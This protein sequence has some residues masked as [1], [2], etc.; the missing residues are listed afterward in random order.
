MKLVKYL[1]LI[2]VLWGIPSFFSYDEAIGSVFSLLMVCALAFYYFI[3][4]KRS[5]LLPFIILGLLY[6]LISGLVMVYGDPKYFRNDLIKYF[7]LIICGAELA[8][9]TTKKEL[10]VILTLGASSILVHALFFQGGFGRYS[11]L[12][13]DPNGAGFVC[14]MAYCLSFNIKPKY[15]KNMG[16]FLVTFAGLLTFSR[17]FIILWLLVSLIAVV[18]DRKNSLNFGLGIGALIIILTVGSLL[19]VDVN[20]FNALESIFNDNQTTQVSVIKEDS[21]TDT[22]ARYYDDILDSPIFGNG[23][24]QLSGYDDTTPGVHNSYLMVIGEAGIFPFLVFIG[25]YLFML[26]KNVARYKTEVFKIMFATTLFILLM[27]THNYFDNF[28]LI[29]VSVWLFI[30]TT[31]TVSDENE[32]EDLDSTETELLNKTL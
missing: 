30:Q 31:E 14:I 16:Q 12:Y 9:D 6:F 19:K 5:F 21:R 8:R 26:F 2:L 17:T 22:W 18:S 10:F 32:I 25:I 23:Y 13:L 28:L 3:S 7:V 24:R 15:L 4:E 1:A 29:F 27:T 20:R 11:G